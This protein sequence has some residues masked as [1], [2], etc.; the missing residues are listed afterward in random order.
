[1]KDGKIRIAKIGKPFFPEPL[2]EKTLVIQENEE[3]FLTGPYPN[4]N[5]IVMN[6][7]KYKGL[8]EE[9]RKHCPHLFIWKFFCIFFL[10][11]SFSLGVLCLYFTGFIEKGW[12]VIKVKK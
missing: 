2:N 11:T 9:L 1:M 10:L 3:L 4:N 5:T 12:Q 7:E 8:V 6:F